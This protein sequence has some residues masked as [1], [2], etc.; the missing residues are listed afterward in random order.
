MRKKQVIN[1]EMENYTYQKEKL[2]L[3]LNKNTVSEI[4]KSKKYTLIVVSPKKLK[5]ILIFTILIENNLFE[6]K[7]KYNEFINSISV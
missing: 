1:Q 4:I 5:S 3:R 2:I 7:E 6:T